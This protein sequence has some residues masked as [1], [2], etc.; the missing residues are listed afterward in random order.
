MSYH[1]SFFHLIT[2]MDGSPIFF[3]K[4]LNND[5]TRRPKNVSDLERNSCNLTPSGDLASSISETVGQRGCC[6]INDFILSHISGNQKAFEQWRCGRTCKYV[7]WSM[8]PCE[9]AS[10]VWPLW[11]QIQSFSL[12]QDRSRPSQ[13]SIN[14]RII[15]LAWTCMDFF[16]WRAVFPVHIP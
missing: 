6:K 16:Y 9:S 5:L 12:P 4:K 13:A 1:T 11:L 15:E 8:R 3:W 14:T 10:M 7:N 2:W